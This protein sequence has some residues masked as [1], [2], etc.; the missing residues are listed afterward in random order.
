MF[1]EK[2]LIQACEECNIQTVKRILFFKRFINLD[3][4]NSEGKTALTASSFFGRVEFMRLL[5]DSG[6]DI[7]ATDKDGRTPLMRA[8]AGGEVEAVDLLIEHGA[9]INIQDNEGD[10]A[11]FHANT[12]Q[13][14]E[15]YDSNGNIDPKWLAFAKIKKMLLRKNAIDHTDTP[16]FVNAAT[17]GFY[18]VAKALIDEGADVK[19]REAGKALL[20]AVEDDSDESGAFVEYMLKKGSDVNT[21][22][23][24]GEPAL[25]LAENNIELVKLLIEYGANVNLAKEG[26]TLLHKA[27]R[28][29][30]FDMVKLLVHNGANVSAVTDYGGWQPIHNACRDASLKTIGFLLENGADICAQDQTG[31]TPLHHAIERRFSATPLDPLLLE[32]KVE[33]IKYLLRHGAKKEIKGRD[34]QTAFDLAAHNGYIEIMDLLKAESQDKTDLSSAL[35]C[36]AENGQGET[37]EA[38]L[39]QGA[40]INAKNSNGDPAIHLSVKRGNLNLVEALVK[41]NADIEGVDKNGCTPYLL[42]KAYGYDDISYFLEKSGADLDVL[43]S[44][45]NSA[46]D[47]E[48]ARSRFFVTNQLYPG[49]R[50][51]DN[52]ATVYSTFAPKGDHGLYKRNYVKKHISYYE[53]RDHI[54]PFF[55]EEKLDEKLQHILDR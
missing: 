21:L 47:L 31:D 46:A 24:I 52:E 30:N 15:E 40:D 26:E 35:L 7:N 8:S 12:N 2:K 49:Y 33:K 34:G 27:A 43:D 25:I 11:Y 10:T 44:Y 18:D 13:G 45:G 23:N 42:S 28:R 37:V 4:L 22:N 17:H 53:F 39:K 51:G 29:D 9:K 19:S 14:N 55:R 41:K 20:Y 32:D 6:A 3:A 16:P 1:F 54:K 5:I 50:W 38:L 48:F 36:A